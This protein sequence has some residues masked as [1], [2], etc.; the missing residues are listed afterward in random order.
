MFRILFRNWLFILTFVAIQYIFFQ[1]LIYKWNSSQWNSTVSKASQRLEGGGGYNSKIEQRLSK[2]IDAFQDYFTS[3]GDE[4]STFRQQSIRYY[5]DQN[6][7]HKLFLRLLKSENP[8]LRIATIG[9]S[10]SVPRGVRVFSTAFYHNIFIELSY[11]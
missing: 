6:N 11:S 10:I 7:V 5:G 9:G 4:F 1:G 3:K 8:S 2:L